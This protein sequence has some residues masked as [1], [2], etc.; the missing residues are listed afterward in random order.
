MKENEDYL[1]MPED[2]GWNY[3]I[4]RTWEYW[5]PCVGFLIGFCCFWGLLFTYPPPVAFGWL[6]AIMWVVCTDPNKE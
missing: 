1:P 4:P 5:R 3:P 6:V 2:S